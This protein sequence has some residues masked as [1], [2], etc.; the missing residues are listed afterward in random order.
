M[1]KNHFFQDSTLH[2]TA[3]EREDTSSLSIEATSYVALTRLFM[4]DLRGSRPIIN[5]LVGQMT[6]DGIFVTSEVCLNNLFML[7]IN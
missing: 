1:Q 3:D 5:W 2:W 7:C 4:G 6:K